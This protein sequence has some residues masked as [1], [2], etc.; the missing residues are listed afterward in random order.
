MADPNLYDDLLKAKEQMKL[1]RAKFIEQL[2]KSL[3]DQERQVIMNR[4]DDQMREMERQLLKEQEDQAKAF[5]A[6]LAN[7]NKLHQHIVEVVKEDTKHENDK[8]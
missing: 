4:F 1:N 6:K 8:I 3:S 2:D 7:R 5:K